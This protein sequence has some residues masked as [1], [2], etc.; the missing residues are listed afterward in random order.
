MLIRIWDKGNVHPLLGGVQTC[1]VII[2]I[3]IAQKLGNN[4]PQYSATP[5]LAIYQKYFIL[6]QGHLLHYVHSSTLRNTQTLET[7]YISFNRK[8]DKNHGTLPQ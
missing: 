7:T 6:L 1:T 8:M 4:L 5:I 2:V 3:N